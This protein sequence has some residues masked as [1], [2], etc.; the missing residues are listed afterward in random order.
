MKSGTK[1]PGYTT[2]QEIIKKLKVNNSV[3][4]MFN[5]LKNKKGIEFASY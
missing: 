2:C 1:I 4:Y 3:D 5:P